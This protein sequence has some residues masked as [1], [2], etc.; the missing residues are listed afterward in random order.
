[1]LSFG[2]LRTMAS[3]LSE[4]MGLA[5][6]AGVTFDGARDLFKALGYKKKLQCEDY[7]A[8]YRRHGIAARVVDTY[9]DATWRKG[10]ELVEDDDVDATTP[11]EE[12]WNDLALRLQVWSVFHR[13]DILASLGRYS[14]ILIGMPGPLDQPAPQSISGPD[15]ITYLTPFA[16]D[17]AVVDE[18]DEDP[19]SPRFGQPKM[20][21]LRRTTPSGAKTTVGAQK[22]H[23]SRVLHV[24]NAPLDDLVYGLPALERV[25][26]YCDDLEKIC[27]GGAEAFWLRVHQGF[28]FNVDP[29]V[30]VGDGEIET[31]REKS[32]EFANGIRRS[33]VTRGME[34]EVKGSD[35]ANF[36]NPVDAVITLI[37]GATEIPK[38]ILVGSERGEL[39]SSQDKTTFDERVSDRRSEF[40]EPRVVRPF[41]ELCIKLGALPKPVKFD[42]FWPQ[43]E[44]NQRESA[45]VAAIVATL[46]A[47]AGGTVILPKE[48]RDQYLGLEPLS[49]E[50]LAEAEGEVEVDEADALNVQPPAPPAETED[51]EDETEEEE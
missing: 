36:S 10:A 6:L 30:E 29:D 40:A 19:T 26:N 28:F 21:T 23:W 11:F 38:R 41:A 4:R 18:L 13:A 9:P 46:N 8:R 20:Y 7:R 25:W 35:V 47:K 5:G 42:V 33:M 50:D 44:N 22:L 3:V 16:E 1:M 45:E 15:Q 34:L 17:D 32:E 12:A 27:G 2:R 49:D 37:A 43:V 48:I 31:M 14:V 51:D 39:A 24:V